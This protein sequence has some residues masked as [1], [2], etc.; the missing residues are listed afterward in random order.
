MAALKHKNGEETRIQLSL[1]NIISI[2]ALAVMII[3]GIGGIIIRTE[4][5]NAKMDN[6][7]EQQV[8]LNEKQDKKNDENV[9][10]HGKIWETLAKCGKYGYNGEHNYR[11][12]GVK[13]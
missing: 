13:R 6:F 9:I 4:I 7:I 8:K 1:A 2:I 10:E 3:G 12:G 5:H 11:Y